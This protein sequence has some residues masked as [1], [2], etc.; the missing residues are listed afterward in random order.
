MI[1]TYLYFK[2]QLSYIFSYILSYI[3][4]LITLTQLYKFQFIIYLVLDS[5]RQFKIDNVFLKKL[6]IGVSRCQRI[7]RLT[8]NEKILAIL[9]VFFRVLK[10][11]AEDVLWYGYVGNMGVPIFFAEKYCPEQFEI[12]DTTPA[13]GLVPKIN[14][15]KCYRRIII[16]RK[17]KWII[18]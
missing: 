1:I 9:L 16:R 5:P 12:V 2:S 17:I 18:K 7:L 11:R 14:E 3:L 6:S 10:C 15:K 4:F 8:V 13:Y